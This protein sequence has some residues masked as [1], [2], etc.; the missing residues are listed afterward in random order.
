MDIFSVLMLVGG[1]AFFLYGMN[2]LSESLEKMAGGKLQGILEKMTSN[3]FKSLMLGALITAAI[4]SSSAVTVMLVGLVNSGIMQLGQTIGVLM[5][6]NIGTTATAWI[7]SLGGIDSDNMWVKLIKPENFTL[8]F[9][10]VG[11]LLLMTAKNQKKKDVGNILVGFAI[12]IYG[13]KMMGDAVNP[14]SESEEFRQVLLAFENPFFGVLMGTVVTAIIQSSSASVGILQTLTDTGVIRYGVAL[15]IIMGQNI[16][17]CVTAVIS[18]IGVNKNAKRVAVVH[19][20]FNLIGTAVCLVLYCIFDYVLALPLFDQFIDRVGVALCHTLFNLFTTIILFP[21]I[22]QL[23][24]LAKFVIKDTE[25]KEKYAFIDERLL[26][27]PSVAIYECNVITQEMAGM[28]KE[29]IERAIALV[30]VY[31][32]EEAERVKKM[33]NKLD[34]YEDE[35]GTFL[36]KLSAK[37]LSEAD[38]RQISKLLHTIGDLERISDHAVS[39]VLA[40]K[41]MQDKAAKFSEHAMQEIATLK[42][43]ILEIL[44]ITMKSYKDNDTELARKVEPLEQVIDRLI[45]KIRHRHIARLK[46]GR[47]T[48]EHG[49]ILSDLLSDLS[50]VSDHCSN[51]AVATI[52]V[53]RNQFE[54]HQYLKKVKYIGDEEFNNSFVEYGLKYELK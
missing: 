49:I 30:D 23:E 41:E 11:I 14:L 10:M 44:E 19:M 15:P 50:R 36:V 46:D 6:S 31:S 51:I 16:G 20:A 45:E 43:A 8:V 37:E 22:G 26:N 13:M 9:A 39:I 1:L 40:A 48:I 38:S 29:T 35:L 21:F 5:G 47:C 32:E 18:S 3:R 54:T 33:E 7:L 12:L 2:V 52:E 28:A 17:T 25:E 42:S 53:D 34:Y 27:T 4:Q 24:K